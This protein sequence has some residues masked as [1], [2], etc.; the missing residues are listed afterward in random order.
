MVVVG[1]VRARGVHDFFEI[2]VDVWG[3][4]MCEEMEEKGEEGSIL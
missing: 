4:S 3:E 2:G 1:P